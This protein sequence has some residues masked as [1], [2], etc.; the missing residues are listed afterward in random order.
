M[1]EPALTVIAE[2]HAKPGREEEL[3]GLLKGLLEPT[4]KERG[5][6][7]Y[8]LHVDND[9]PGHFL[10][11]ENWA[12]MALLQAHLGS[13]HLTAFQARSAD[14]LDEPLRIVFASRIG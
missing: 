4:R 11:V 3:G 7:Q 6:V 13:P 8:D 12:S 10:F 2:F 14:L 5:C 1:N 9:K